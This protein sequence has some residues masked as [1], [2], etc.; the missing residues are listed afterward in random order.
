MVWLF[1][2]IVLVLIVW[3]YLSGRDS[4]APGQLAPDFELA[5]QNGELHSLTDFRGKWLALYFYPKDDT[6]GCTRQACGF[7]DGFHKLK[8]LDAEVVGISIDTVDS[9]AQFAKNFGLPFRLLADTTAETS[10]R[11]HS[12]L[13]LGIVKFAK[14]NTFLIDPLGRIAKAYISVNATR[15]AADIVSDLERLKISEVN[16]IKEY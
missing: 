16:G 6:P 2:I 15:N 8:A 10:A 5:D 12:L 11:Y 7:R 13:N 9:H 14:R 4:L 1:I 3:F